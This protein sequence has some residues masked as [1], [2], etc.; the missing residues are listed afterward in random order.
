[1]LDVIVRLLEGRGA[2]AHQVWLP[3]LDNPPSM[4]EL[5]PGLSRCRDGA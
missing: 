2:S 1:M 5:L 4:D 3:P